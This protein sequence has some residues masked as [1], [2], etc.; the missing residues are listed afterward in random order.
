VR[1][2]QLGLQPDGRPEVRLGEPADAFP[3]GGQSHRIVRERQR[4]IDGQRAP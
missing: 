2:G 4:W 1:L 3:Q